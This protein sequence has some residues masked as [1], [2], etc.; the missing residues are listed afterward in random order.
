VNGGGVVLLLVVVW[1]IPIFVAARVTIGKGRGP[2]TGVLLGVFLGWIG[3]VIAVCLGDQRS[4]AGVHA[5]TQRMYRECPHCRESMRRD[6]SVCPHC[7]GGSQAWTW[8]DDRWW[9]DHNGAW[10]WL[11]SDEA[12]WVVYD[13]NDDLDDVD[14]QR[15]CPHCRES[16]RRGAATCRHCG[17]D[18]EP[19]V[20]HGHMWWLHHSGAWHWL[21][22]D[23]TEWVPYNLEEDEVA[24]PPRVRQG[25]PPSTAATAV[26]GGADG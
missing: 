2:T 9:L 19:W 15:E 10:Y 26:T 21:T 4:G 6:A 1:V 24:P 14:M 8:D 17:N 11:S 22:G 25:G 5:Q 12:E 3:V 16:M 18:S 20:W 7:R 13:P 23:E